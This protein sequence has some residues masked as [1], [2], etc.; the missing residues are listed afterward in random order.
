MS[1][2]VGNTSAVKLAVS[3]G[4]GDGH[5]LHGLHL[6]GP[7]LQE[8][9]T[10]RLL[11][12]RLGWW[13]IPG[14]FSRVIIRLG[15]RMVRINSMVIRL[16]RRCIRIRMIVRS[17]GRNI[18]GRSRC[19]GGGLIRSWLVGSRSIGFRSWVVVGLQ[20]QGRGIT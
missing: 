15:R 13:P 14:R 19:I 2:W 6:V 4:H 16:G 8:H 18:G 17:V 9:G 11:I 20:L 5:W 1:V 12:G 10:N 3:L 7:L